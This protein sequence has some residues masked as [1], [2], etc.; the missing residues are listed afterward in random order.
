VQPK[1]NGSRRGKDKKQ[2]TLTVG[3][4]TVT[5]TA[6]ERK[7]DGKSIG[8]RVKVPTV[9]R[10]GEQQYAFVGGKT[11]D[12]TFARA[13]A[14][15]ES[16]PDPSVAPTKAATQKV[17]A[18]F[19]WWLDN[20]ITPPATLAPGTSWKYQPTTASTYRFTY[21]KHIAP[22][23]GGVQ[24]RKLNQAE[25]ETMVDNMVREGLG[26]PTI[27]F[28]VK[29][30]RAAFASAIEHKHRKL[31]GLSIDPARHLSPPKGAKPKKYAADI[32]EVMRL[33]SA[34]EA[35]YVEDRSNVFPT[36]HAARKPP[37]STLP[38]I[39]VS[40]GLRR[41]E[42]LGLTWGDFDLERRQLVLRRQVSRVDSGTVVRLGTKWNAG[43]ESEPLELPDMTIEA[44]RVQQTRLKAHRLRVGRT[45]KGHSDPCAPEAPVFPTYFGTVMSPGALHAWFVDLCKV[46]NVEGKTLHKLRH[47]CASFHRA[48]GTRDDQIMRIMRHKHAGTLYRYLHET[49]VQDR[50]VA[51]DNMDALLR[52]RM[53]TG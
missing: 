21:R 46:A 17:G 29:V 38:V 10:N 5:L 14:Y 4:R 13:R 47:D 50:R 48:S 42:I 23:I 53:R 33:V 35:Q 52:G 28:V 12:E 40:L 3:D 36:F 51:A 25:L 34:A 2:R 37:L 27:R 19:E 32:N 15:M 24:L 44:L 45:W 6:F 9:H 16:N 22:R 43:E 18:W 20:V 7:K 1:S 8:F 26:L 31:S 39:A 49:N 41:G 11:L 30:M